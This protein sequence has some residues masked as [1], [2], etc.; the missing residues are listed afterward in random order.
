MDSSKTIKKAASTT[1]EVRQGIIA[2]ALA[3]AIWGGM[4]AVSR[5]VLESIPPLTLVFIRMCI[6]FSVLI[7]GLMLLRRQWWLPRNLWLQVLL[8]GF[9]GYSLSIGAQFIGTKLAGAALGSLITTAA[10]IVT[11]AIAAVLGLE[12]VSI[13]AWVGLVFGLAGVAVL[14]GSNTGSIEGIVWLLVAAISWGILGILGG[15]AVK[16]ADAV[17]ITAWASLVGAVGV[18]PFLPTELATSGIG[19]I[20]LGTVLGILYLGIV[21][22]AGAFALWVYG[23]SRAGAVYSGLAYFAQPLVGAVLGAVVL[24]EQLGS[25]FALGAVL[26]ILGVMIA[27]K[28]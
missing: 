13:F 7:V 23:V 21:S 10:P 25:G 17:L 26:L 9:I 16:K 28:K 14:S 15:E 4:Y 6:S 5:V 19:T 18:L 27:Q 3:S 24:G 2:A 12:K 22:T 20:S 1:T 8:I 11:V